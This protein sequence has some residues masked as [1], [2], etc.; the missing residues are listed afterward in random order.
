MVSFD[1][2]HI[3]EQGQDMIIVPMADD[4]GR[5]RA[6]DQSAIETQLAIAA[7]S[8]GLAGCIVTIWKASG[9]R[10]EFRA[11]RPWHPFFTSIDLNYI[12]ANINRRITI[13]G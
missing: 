10:M 11:P 1:V 8:A 9:G 13:N 3:R 5:R 2:A 7:R 4:Y 12:V 6:S